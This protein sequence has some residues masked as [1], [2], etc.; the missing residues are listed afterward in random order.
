MADLILAAE[1]RRSSPGEAP[2]APAQR[3]RRTPCQ[4]LFGEI[5][6]MPRGAAGQA[7]ERSVLEGWSARLNRVPVLP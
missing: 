4:G 7:L 5:E 2:V 3:E 1:G 6:A